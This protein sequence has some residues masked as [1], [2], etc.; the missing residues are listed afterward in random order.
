MN[1]SERR[2]LTRAAVLILASGVVR[3]GWEVRRGPPVAPASLGSDLPGLLAEATALNEEERRRIEPLGEGE[4]IE[5]NRVGEVDLDR[6]PGVGP[7]TAKA[8]VES[9]DRRGGFGALE[10]LLEVRG[11][12]PATLEKIRPHVELG[13]GTP[14]TARGRRVAVRRP[15]P[16]PGR[17]VLSPEA[18]SGR[19]RQGAAGS[20]PGTAAR[21][22]PSEGGK[23]RRAGPETPI[24]VNRASEEELQRLPGIG[25][26]LA[27]RIV[28]LRRSRGR[29][30]SVDSLVVVQG[31]GPATLARIRD[32]IVAR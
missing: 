9:R 15:P 11:I 5:L 12:G 21:T 17:S 2:A 1:P 27:A 6:L 10:E 25:P 26:A 4:R 24:D 29:F 13:G 28:N 20:A 19:A 31:I 7:S 30:T 22:D 3:W 16:A 18:A 23:A 8:I 32:R 14:A